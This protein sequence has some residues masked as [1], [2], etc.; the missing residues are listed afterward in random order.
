MKK[1]VLT[2]AFLGFVGFGFAQQAP[3]SKKNDPQM[4]KEMAQK[5]QAERIAKMKSDLSLSQEQ[6]SKLETLYDKQFE[7]RQKQMEIMR[8]ERV[9]KA[10]DMKLKKEKMDAEMKQILT[11]E[12]YAKWQAERAERMKLHAEEMKNRRVKM[13]NKG[14]FHKKNVFEEKGQL[15]K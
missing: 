9:K 10:A 3:V 7:E 2:I 5:K 1:T 15:A 11:S 4:H 12:Q 6:V 8:E 14:G 13:Q